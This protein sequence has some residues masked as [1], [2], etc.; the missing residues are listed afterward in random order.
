MPFAN[1][2][3]WAYVVGSNIDGGIENYTDSIPNAYV[4]DGQL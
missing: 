4:Q 2:Q 1:P 3:N